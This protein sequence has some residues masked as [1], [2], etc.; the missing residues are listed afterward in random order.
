MFC[1][2]LMGSNACAFGELYVV[3]NATREFLWLASVW[4]GEARVGCCEGLPCYYVCT[5]LICNVQTKELAGNSSVREIRGLY[6]WSRL[7]EHG[8]QGS[9]KIVYVLCV[10]GPYLFGY[11]RLNWILLIGKIKISRLRTSLSWACTTLY[12]KMSLEQK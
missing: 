6:V 2:H 8:R 10:F 11:K 4:M 3:C 12:F 9:L 7:G 5:S 1:E